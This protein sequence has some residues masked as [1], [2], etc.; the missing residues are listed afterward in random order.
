MHRTKSTLFWSLLL[1]STFAFAQSA[2]LT[3]RASSYSVD[4][5]VAKIEAAAK[6]R[7]VSVFAKIDHAAEAKKAGLQMPPTLLLIVGN[8]KAGTPMMLE[9]PSTAIDLPLKI[10]VAQGADGKTAVTLNDAAF[11]RNRHGLSEDVAKPLAGA[12]ALV[13]AALK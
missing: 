1:C 3:T 4:E 2:G 8:P 7:G 11:M 12:A 13:E 6:E 5:T 9:K 10:L